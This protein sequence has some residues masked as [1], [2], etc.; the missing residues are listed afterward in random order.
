MEKLFMMKI[1]KDKV[2]SIPEGRYPPQRMVDEMFGRIPSGYLD[3]SVNHFN[4]RITF[5]T[6]DKFDIKF[7]P[8]LF[9]FMGGE[10]HP[11]P[12]PGHIFK[13]SSTYS[14]LKVV[15]YKRACHNLFIYCDLIA[16]RLVGNTFASLLSTVP[17][18]SG[19]TFGD[20]LEKVFNPIRYFK[21][22][23]QRFDTVKL[24]ILNDIGERVK[25]EDGKILI[26]L[27][28]KKV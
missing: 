24:D 4:R 10:F 15:D 9:E 27:H 20:T 2:Y 12:H 11:K 7:N 18:P 1:K 26:E 19:G 22:S 16:P 25:F 14:G 8:A 23:K 17:N 13:K 3:V 21:I 5:K 6:G 28:F